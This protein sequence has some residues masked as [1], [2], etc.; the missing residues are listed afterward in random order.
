MLNQLKDEF[1]KLNAP[2]SA[3]LLS[4]LAW[5]YWVF[6]A[7]ESHNDLFAVKLTSMKTFPSF[8]ITNGS[9][10]WSVVSSILSMVRLV[11]LTLAF[12][13]ETT[14]EDSIVT[15][16]MLELLLYSTPS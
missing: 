9:G 14:I 15:L 7:T 1:E 13:T 10:F 11:N 3:V 5:K 8:C 12:T 2:C 16:N 6:N 4:A